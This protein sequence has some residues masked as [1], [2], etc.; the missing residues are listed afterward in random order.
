MSRRASSKKYEK[1]KVF[2][3]ACGSRGERVC[4]ISDIN[5]IA[6]TSQLK[7]EPDLV[8]YDHLRSAGHVDGTNVDQWKDHVVGVLHLNYHRT[9][10]VIGERSVVRS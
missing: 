10:R 3:K 7:K 6:N 9:A 5:S 1:A 8:D 2:R 4:Y